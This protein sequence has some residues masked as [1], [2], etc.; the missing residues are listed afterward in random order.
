MVHITLQCVYDRLNLNHLYNN[1]SGLNFAGTING[2][3]DL[4]FSY[5]VY[6]PNIISEIRS[7]SYDELNSSTNIIGGSWF[8]NSSIDQILNIGSNSN[9]TNILTQKVKS[10]K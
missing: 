2:I 3:S 6:I 5:I 9:V 10:E 4:V 8:E 7:I 1:T